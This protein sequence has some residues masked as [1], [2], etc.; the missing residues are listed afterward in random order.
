MLRPYVLYVATESGTPTSE[1]E[2]NNVPGAANPVPASG[3]VTGVISP[4]GTTP[5]ADWFSFTGNAGDTVVVMLDADPERDSLNFNP[6]LGLG[7][8]NNFILLATDA[9]TISPNAEQMLITLGSSGTHYVYVDNTVAG[10]GPTATYQFSLI[11]YP[12][13]V[14]GVNCTTYTSTNVPVAIPVSRLHIPL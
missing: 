5:D 6:R 10:G 1:T 14:Q 7:V 4:T 2:P 3:W 8:F 9:N 13:T 12:K 11:V